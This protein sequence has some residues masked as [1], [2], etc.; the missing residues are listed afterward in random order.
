LVSRRH[1]Q[2]RGIFYSLIEQ[3]H[4]RVEQ[5]PRLM[6]DLKEFGNPL[7]ATGGIELPPTEAAQKLPHPQ[8]GQR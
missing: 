3:D 5:R 6:P 4:C 2:S 1:F 8:I 7:V